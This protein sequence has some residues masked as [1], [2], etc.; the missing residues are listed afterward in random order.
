MPDLAPM[1]KGYR[2]YPRGFLGAGLGEQIKTPERPFA[3]NLRAHTYH[4]GWLQANKPAREVNRNIESMW[5][6]LND[7]HLAIDDIEF[8][9]KVL[10][11]ALNAFG[12]PDFHQWLTVQMDGPSTGDL[13]MDFLQ[14]TLRFIETGRRQMNL[15]SWSQMLSLSDVTHNDT[16]NEGQFAWFFQNETQQS[17]NLSVI[18]VVQRW[19]SQSSGFADLVQT[20]HVLFGDVQPR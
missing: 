1:Y 14:D 11:V 10:R 4:P 17:K 18:D 3:I 12:T 9:E 20:L 2:V 7:H 19:C 6:H 5:R 15:H 16:P 13:H 8:R